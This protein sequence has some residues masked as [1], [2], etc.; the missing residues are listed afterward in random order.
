LIRAIGDYSMVVLFSIAG[1][2]KGSLC[3]L[4]LDYYQLL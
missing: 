1:I 3:S 2:P 4:P